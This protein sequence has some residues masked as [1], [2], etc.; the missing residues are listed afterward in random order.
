MK[1]SVACPRAW[2][3]AMAM[4]LS[5]LATACGGGGQDPILGAGDTALLVRAT[6]TSVAPLPRA[7]LVPLNTRLITATFSKAMEGASL[8]TDSFTLTCPS[9]AA[10]T[11]RAVT[12]F[13]SDKTAT[14]ALPA[15]TLLPAGEVCTTTVGAGVRDATGATLGQDVVWQFTTGSA[16]DTTAPLITS[17]I[18]A[19]GA[20]NVSVNT[21]VG[22]TFSEAMDPLTLAAPT[23]TLMQGSNLV[24]G[25]T[26]YSGVSAVFVPTSALALNTSYTATVSSS[27]KD[28]AGNAMAANYVWSWTTG[29]AL[30]TT[31]PTVTG[32]V[33]AN[34]AVNVAINTQAGVAFSEA[35]NPLSIKNTNVVLRESA[36]AVVVPGVVSYS[37]VN[38]AFM[39]LTS[40]LPGTRYTL[41]VKG[42]AA[43]VEDVA[44]NP[45]AADFI[46]GWTTAGNATPMDR[47]APT[48]VMFNPDDLATGVATSAT[49]NATFDEA[50]DPLS[51]NTASFTVAGVA[52]SVAYNAAQRIATFTPAMPLAKG[53]LYTVIVS[54]AVADL[55]GNTMKQAKVWRFTTAVDPVVPVN[56]GVTP[57]IALNSAARFGTFGG[58]AGMTNMGTLTLINGDIG[59]TATGTS[60]VTGFHDAA[61]DFYTETGDNIGTVNGKIYSCT[62][63]VTGPTS[64]GTNAASCAAAT[65]ARLDAQTA[66]QALVA[67]PAGA[68]PG[69]NLAGLTLLPGTYTAP[70][71]SF[72]LEGGNLTLDAQGNA[73]A[74]WVFQMATTL[75]V[76]GPGAA[77]P[78]SIILAGGAQA[79]NVF[80]QVG[81]FATINAAGGG[82]MVGT[83]ISQRGA[84]F[85]TAGNVAVVTLNGRALSLGASVTLV[86]TVINVPQ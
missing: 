33:Q 14:L 72:M 86:N 34:N 38:A 69:A 19:N 49:V 73:N 60:M 7:A 21:K 85:S 83:V 61:G 32:T 13:E 24:P 26:S 52:G 77:F 84:S 54:T 11:S 23:F 62:N 22:A 42:G 70:A 51:I 65:Q 10:T 37:G 9:L 20:T 8:G 15:D 1:K 12:Y 6:V 36:S 29:A 59:T 48:V 64:T 3:W 2:P 57:I 68:N 75:T 30:D 4:S 46:T 43:G 50:M 76:G 79:K 63:S 74:V 5:A 78:Q 81:S 67:M 45:M 17:T 56:P 27:A 39:P 55:A 58:T 35:M 25:N 28:L 18:N 40:L 31:A 80:W 53:T 44:G 16:L 66:Y 47:T 41:T 71:G 82:T